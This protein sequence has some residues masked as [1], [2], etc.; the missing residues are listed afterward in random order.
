MLN[1]LEI[2]RLA[3][4]MAAHAAQ[5]HSVIA[6]NI[7]NADTPNYKSLD[8]GEFRSRVEGSDIRGLR[9]TRGGHLHSLSSPG[10][11]ASATEMP[12][13]SDG[14]GNTVNLE[15]EMVRMASNRQAHDLA[16]SVYK[17]ALNILRASLGRG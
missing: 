10:S 2:V 3:G 1:N 14:N 5:R 9:T 12:G 13:A 17:S 16:T 11:V 4:D 6:R 15:Q 7:A 8:I